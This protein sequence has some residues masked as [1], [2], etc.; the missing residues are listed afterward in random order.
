M[1]TCLIE[2]IASFKKK[3]FI[4]TQISPHPFLKSQNFQISKD[5]E[6]PQPTFSWYN[7]KLL[8]LLLEPC[9]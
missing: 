9:T 5:A 1:N 7:G 6:V 4:P 8:N 2:A 3:G